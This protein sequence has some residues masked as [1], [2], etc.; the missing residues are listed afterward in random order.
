MWT[1]ISF[2]LLSSSK[3]MFAPLAGPAAGLTFWETFITCSIGGYISATI[4]YFG[5]SYFMKLSLKRYAKRVKKAQLKGKPVPVKRKITKTNRRIIQSKQKIGQIFTCW[6]FPL[7]FSI[8]LGT[9]ITAKFYK[10]DRQTF[11]LIILFLTVD[12]FLITGGTYFIKDLVL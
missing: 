2:V 4:F 7:F 10:H 5:S 8:P 6:A 9:I 1:Y 12:C 11:P 3:F